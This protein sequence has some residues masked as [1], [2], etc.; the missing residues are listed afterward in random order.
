MFL[1]S[2]MP[3]SIIPP[4]SQAVGPLVWQNGSQVARLNIPLNP[5]FLIYD[6]SVTK[7]GD[8]SAQSPVYLP[9]L[10]EIESSNFAYFL[11]VTGAGLVGKATPSMNFSNNLNGGSAGEVPYQSA[12]STTGFI[13]SGTTGQILSSNGTAIPSWLNQSDIVSGGFTGLLVGDVTGTQGAT[14]VSNVGGRTASDVS[15]AVVTVNAATNLNTASALIKRDAS[16]NFSAGTITASLSGNATSATTSGTST[17]ATNFTGSLV[18][19]VTGTQGATSVVKVNGV[20]LPITKTIIGTNGSGQIIDASSATLTNNT[21]GNSATSTTAVNFTG[22][23]A[24]DVTGTQGAN[25]VVKVNG[26]AIPH[27]II[28]IGTNGSG[29]I[30]DATSATL[31]NNT[32]GNAA[33]AT[34]TANFSGSLVGDVTGTQGATSVT[35]VNGASVPVSKTIVGTNSAGR[36]VDASS[37]MLSNNTS[38]NAATATNAINAVTSTNFGG[39]LSGDVTGTQGATLVVNVNGVAVPTSKTIVGTNGSGQ[40]IDA[41]SATLANNTTGSSATATSVSGG[42]AGEVLYQSA[43]GVTAFTAVGTSGQILTS[44]GTSPPTWAAAGTVTTATNLANGAASQIPYQ[45]GSGATAFIANGTAGQI[46]FSNGTTAPSWGQE[47]SIVN[48]L[49]FG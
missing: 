7:W 8:G 15:S 41:S 1:P 5:S 19:D 29:Q 46:L 28:I 21:T 24:G 30:I 35:R 43:S 32:T 17:T 13:P 9:A 6:G 11:G 22:S 25:S 18:G 44:N 33:T 36:I 40:I 12:V 48:A 39:S 27:S 14:V 42:S 38:G 26:S 2:Q 45:T 4:V 10:Q 31:S 16:G 20:S 37:A 34:A 47:P 23:L 49:I 3:I